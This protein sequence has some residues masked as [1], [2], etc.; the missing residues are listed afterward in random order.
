[1]VDAIPFAWT[2]EG[3]EELKKA[4]LAVFVLLMLLVL[5]T[6][7]KTLNLASA[8]QETANEKQLT[9]GSGDDLSPA[10]SPDGSR[11]LFVRYEPRLVDI[12]KTWWDNKTLSY[13]ASLWIVYMDGTL[14]GP[15]VESYFP[16]SVITG[17][18][19]SRNGEMIIYATTN[20][21]YGPW[22]KIVGS[23]LWLIDLNSEQKTMLATFPDRLIL[24]P[25]ELPDG[26]I[27]FLSINESSI[28]L[29]L[30][31]KRGTQ[32]QRIDSFSYDFLPGAC[33]SPSGVTL[34]LLYGTDVILIGLPSGS[35]RLLP[36]TLGVLAG[37]YWATDSDI[38]FYSFIVDF[39]KEEHTLTQVT[40]V[41]IESGES[42][43]LVSSKSKSQMPYKF[44]AIWLPRIW[45]LQ[46]FA[47][48]ITTPQINFGSGFVFGNISVVESNTPELYQADIQLL[49]MN[50]DGTARTQLFSKSIDKIDYR[51]PG[52]ALFFSYAVRRDGVI[53]LT[54]PST[55]FESWKIW[56]LNATVTSRQPSSI[57]ISLS[58]SATYANQP[59]SI[60][61]SLTPPITTSIALTF[62]KPDG[63]VVSTSVTT[64]ANGK[65][66][67]QFTPDQE[68]IWKVQAS[69][70]G[71]ENYLPA[72]SNVLSFEVRARPATFQ[73]ISY[74][75]IN[76]YQEAWDKDGIAGVLALLKSVFYY[77]DAT[78]ILKLTNSDKVRSIEVP[79]DGISYIITPGLGITI[80]PK[81]KVS[82]A[83]KTGPDEY[84]IRIQVSG[85]SI[86][87][88]MQWA[89]AEIQSASKVAGAI[90]HIGA[91]L[92]ETKPRTRL[93]KV[94]IVDTDG[95]RHELQLGINL[96]YYF[97]TLPEG[98]R[99]AGTIIDVWSP[100][101][102][103]VTDSQG[104]RVGALYKS[105]GTFDKEVNEIPGAFYS[106]RLDKGEFI[107]LP[108]TINQFTIKAVA[109]GEG[110]Y[111][112]RVIPLNE[113]AVIKKVTG[114]IK[115]NQIITYNV[116][117]QGQI[118]QVSETTTTN[119]VSN[120][121]PVIYA[122]LAV[123]AISAGGFVAS[124]ML[125]KARHR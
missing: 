8:Q 99:D 25:L 26:Q 16:Q 12:V 116:D 6:D 118:V 5:P 11:L 42:R 122:I 21:I 47:F 44:S 111:T 77:T 39:R 65:F 33:L 4:K 43:L 109:S 1:V 92:V 18:S 40:K 58:S 66:T 97:S 78:V 89:S 63:S 30:V 103:L 28:D 86:D 27:F 80:A 91:R 96:P 110:Q 68:G 35:Q 23:E 114:I 17:A 90:S 45:L 59:I 106:G 121:S 56:L 61:G 87:V 14:K 37:C 98:L 20:I 102:L 51:K 108:P 55:G 117:I 75:V 107:Y 104:R 72:K 73:L 41:N 38:L 71:N 3:V 36:Q 64:D 93:E 2:C 82:P 113:N 101:D 9:F 94:V 85:F 19:W 70:N 120:V 74:Q 84:S 88:L 10:W 76:N 32:L 34:A 29:N 67:Y 54:Y 53:A 79:V 24:Y 81:G 83:T 57:D 125:R 15:L 46:P 48:V 22:T 112:I 50:L 115:Q 31:N 95:N 7:G 119:Q 52:L 123:V 105:D 100:I 62:T 60:I 13:K 124:R 69:W 49:A